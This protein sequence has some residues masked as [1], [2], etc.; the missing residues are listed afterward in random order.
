MANIFP[1]SSHFPL[2]PPPEQLSLQC[3][4]IVQSY[5][6][7]CA[8]YSVL[9]SV[10][11]C[12]TLCILCY[13]M[14]SIPSV[15]VWASVQMKTNLTPVHWFCFNRLAAKILSHNKKNAKR[16]FFIQEVEVR[17]WS[18]ETGSKNVLKIVSTVYNLVYIIYILFATIW[19]WLLPKVS[20]WIYLEPV[21]ILQPVWLWC[22]GFNYLYWRPVVGVHIF[23]IWILFI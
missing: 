12:Y 7:L 1:W 3:G 5:S 2:P 18:G 16:R 21:R 23:P 17:W 9:H 11:Q 20:R 6:L 4:T 8:V 22:R 14:F 15:S 19:R 10:T 13:E